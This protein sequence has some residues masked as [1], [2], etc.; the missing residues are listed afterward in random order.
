M[1]HFEL[2]RILWAVDPDEGKTPLL[3]KSIDVVSKLLKLPG[4]TVQPI[5]VLRN[6]GVLSRDFSFAWHEP[7]IQAAQKSFRSFL[8]SLRLSGLAPGEVLYRE[9]SSTR[10]SVDALSNYAFEKR[11]DL[12]IAQ[13]HGKKGLARFFVGSF[14]ELLLMRSKVQVMLVNPSTETRRSGPVFDTILFP[15]DFGSR[16]YRNFQTAM[17]LAQNFKASRLCVYHAVRHPMD[18][19]SFFYTPT[20]GPMGYLP[21]LYEQNFKQAQDRAD[22]WKRAAQDRGVPVEMIL[23]RDVLKTADRILQIARRKKAALIAMESHS[24]PIGAF[25]LGS[26]TRKVVRAAPCPIW[27]FRPQRTRS[28]E[29]LPSEG[30][31]AA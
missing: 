2:R 24:G 27:V 25:L 14:A 12:I 1:T 8:S 21:E 3:K 6:E 17:D 18:E 11:A 29:S 30:T 22:R 19:T 26:V 4:V 28:S 23:E 20:I 7:Y 9:T 5:Y 10:T 31:Q 13:T 16:A 15:T